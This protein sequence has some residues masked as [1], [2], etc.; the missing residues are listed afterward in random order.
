MVIMAGTVEAVEAVPMEWL[1]LV[2]GNVVGKVGH[3]QISSLTMTALSGQ[4]GSFAHW[5][6]VQ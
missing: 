1:T 3:L 5:G 6:S 2:V 4:Q